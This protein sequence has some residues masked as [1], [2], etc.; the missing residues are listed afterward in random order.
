MPNAVIIKKNDIM[1]HWV[2]DPQHFD[3]LKRLSLDRKFPFNSRQGYTVSVNSK[4]LCDNYPFQIH[5]LGQSQEERRTERKGN[6]QTYKGFIK[7]GVEEIENIRYEQHYLKIEHNPS[8]KNNA[9]CNIIL[10]FPENK[11]ITA[12]KQEMIQDLIA[13]F[14]DKITKP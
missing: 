6:P 9:H 14:G 8:N 1:C 11:P 4:I 5:N 3:G 10:K 2:F 7:A 12:K 13:C